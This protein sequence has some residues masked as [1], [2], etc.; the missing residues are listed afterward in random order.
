MG[1]N[2]SQ[3]QLGQWAQRVPGP[4]GPMGPNGTRAQNYGNLS[5]VAFSGRIA[6][7]NTIDMAI[8]I[9]M[10]LGSGGL[11]GNLHSPMAVHGSFTWLHMLIIA[12][13]LSYNI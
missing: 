11:S 6:Q 2:G 13:I 9:N 1:P 10:G 5:V 3:A 7:H 8:Y 12:D 4:G